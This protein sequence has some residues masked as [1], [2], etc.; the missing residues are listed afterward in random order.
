MQK[1]TQGGCQNEKTKKHGP[2]E[3]TDPNSRKR[4]KQNGDKQPIRCRVQNT[5][6]QMFKELIGHFNRKKKKA[7]MKLTLSEIKENLWENNKT[8]VE[9][10]KMR[11]K[12]MICNTRK[13]NQLE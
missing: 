7:E 2:N 1:Q 6:Y 9:G 13:K 8:I 12:S 4:A 5:G 10:I 3:R 11:T